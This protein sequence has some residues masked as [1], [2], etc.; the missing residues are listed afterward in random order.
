MYTWWIRVGIPAIALFPTTFTHSIKNKLLYIVLKKLAVNEFQCA[1]MFATVVHVV[2][3][4]V[5]V[6]ATVVYVVALW[7]VEYECR[8]RDL[9]SNPG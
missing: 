1:S 7:P 2:A 3:T 8:A 4:V 9:G 5:Y 6:V